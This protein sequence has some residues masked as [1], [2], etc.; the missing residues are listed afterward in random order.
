MLDNV[1][2]KNP[3]DYVVYLDD[4]RDPFDLLEDENALVDQIDAVSVWDL[5]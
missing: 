5:G 2:V 4:S 1:R 3:D